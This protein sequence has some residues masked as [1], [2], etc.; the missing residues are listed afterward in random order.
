M[1]LSVTNLGIDGVENV[2]QIGTGGSS[3]VYRARQIDLDRVVAIK[4]LNPGD[5]QGVAKRFDRERKAMG[6]LSLHEGIVPVYSSGITDH[7]EP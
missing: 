6:R 5:D 2:E 3:R 1:A 4:V 7:G